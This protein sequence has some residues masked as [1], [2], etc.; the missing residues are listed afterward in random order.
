MGSRPL[1][2]GAAS[3]LSGKDRERWGSGVHSPAKSASPPGPRAPRS[4]SDTATTPMDVGGRTPRTWAKWLVRALAL[5]AF[6]VSLA[7]SARSDDGQASQTASQSAGAERTPSAPRPAPVTVEA[8]AER[9]RA[10]E[11][12][13][14]KLVEQLEQTRRESE[15]TGREHDAQI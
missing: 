6:L 9:L 15:K 10:M 7:A 3:Q 12:V 4:I 2:R 11:E 14:K 13:N 8:L 1:V 5:Y